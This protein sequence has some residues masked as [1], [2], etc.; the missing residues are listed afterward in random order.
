MKRWSKLLQLKGNYLNSIDCI[1]GLSPSRYSWNHGPKLWIRRKDVALSTSIFHYRQRQHLS[2]HTSFNYN[3]NEDTRERTLGLALGYVEKCGWTNEALVN[4]ARDA[5]LSAMQ[6]GALE[7]APIDIVYHFLNRKRLRVQELIMD[8]NT[9]KI[10]RT[11]NYKLYQSIT[12]HIEY[13]KPYKTS[14][15]AAIALLLDPRY[16]FSSL[17]ILLETINDLCSFA[18]TKATQMDWYSER[19][20][21]TMLYSATE[22]YMLTD[23]SDDHVD[24]RYARV[25]QISTIV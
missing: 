4:G 11:F 24:T 19:L 15:P 3:E 22:M 5:N 17:S 13:L 8:E 14:W 23:D 18:D 7:I 21:I 10:E 6:I 20:L 9:D 1:Q 16:A 12:F 2:T 25:L